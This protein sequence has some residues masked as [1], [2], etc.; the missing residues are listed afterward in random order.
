MFVGFQSSKTL[1][2]KAVNVGFL[3]RLRFV[4]QTLFHLLML[5][6]IQRR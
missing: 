2:L 4:T 5:E 1:S 6:R 3:K